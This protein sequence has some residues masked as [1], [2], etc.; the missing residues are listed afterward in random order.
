MN[1]MIISQLC[2]GYYQINRAL[3]SGQFKWMFVFPLEQHGDRG[4]EFCGRL[5]AAGGEMDH[6]DKKYF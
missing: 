3:R 4:Q 1:L 6:A 5:A 2:N